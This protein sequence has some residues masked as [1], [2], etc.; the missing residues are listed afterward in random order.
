VLNHVLTYDKS[1]FAACPG[2][3]VVWEGEQ[4]AIG[5][6]S[7]IRVFTGEELVVADDV[8]GGE[9]VLVGEVGGHG[10]GLG[11]FLSFGYVYI[12]YRS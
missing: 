12:I 10:C 4:E 7:F 1:Y 3:F 5:S 2:L 6:V 11:N 8:L 9:K